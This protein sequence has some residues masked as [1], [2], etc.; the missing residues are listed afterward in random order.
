MACLQA[1]TTY[2]QLIKCQLHVNGFN[3]ERY[4]LSALSEMFDV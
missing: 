4:N 3:H 1:L 2:T